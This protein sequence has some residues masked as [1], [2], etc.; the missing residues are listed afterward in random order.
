MVVE[1]I[2]SLLEVL[3]GSGFGWWQYSG[4]TCGGWV[5]MVASGCW[6]GSVVMVIV[7]NGQLCW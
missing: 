4:G 6:D 5:L 3:K 1:L 7:V 2:Y